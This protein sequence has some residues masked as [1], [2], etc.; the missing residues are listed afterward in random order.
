MRMDGLPLAE[1]AIGDKR[2]GVAAILEDLE[3]QQPLDTT[4]DDED[5]E[6]SVHMSPSR[7]GR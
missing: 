7:G 4:A 1:V 2:R 3:G 6:V 5:V